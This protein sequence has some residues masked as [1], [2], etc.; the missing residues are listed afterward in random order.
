M[1]RAITAAPFIY[2]NT[3]LIRRRG[4]CISI[5]TNW[6]MVNIIFN[7]KFGLLDA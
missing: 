1:G 6:I 3:I 2:R 4:I 7:D 5:G